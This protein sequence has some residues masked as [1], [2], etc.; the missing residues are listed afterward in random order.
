MGP[1]RGDSIRGTWREASFTGD[2]E[3]YV[4]AVEWASVSIRA[5]L[6]GEHGRFFLGVFEIQIY[7]EI[8]KNALE[9][10]ICLHMGPTGEP[11]GDLLAG[12]LREN[13][14]ISGFLS[15]TQRILRFYVWRPS[16][17]L[18]EG[19]GSPELISDCGAQGAHL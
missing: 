11:G 16:G 1:L 7:Q 18:V 14:S 13:E 15:W 12:T 8:Y 4:K 9:A 19:Q 6:F 10:G 17:T 5:L 2:P 3:K